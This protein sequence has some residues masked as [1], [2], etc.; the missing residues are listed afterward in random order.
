MKTLMSICT[1]IALAATGAAESAFDGTWTFTTPDGGAGWLSIDTA[2]TPPKVDMLWE[3][4]GVEPAKEA[5]LSRNTLAFSFPWDH[6]YMTASGMRR[7]NLGTLILRLIDKGSTVDASLSRIKNGATRLYADGPPIPLAIKRAAPMPPA[8]DVNAL[9][10]GDPIELFDGKTLGGWRLTNPKDVSGWSVKDGILTN[11]PKLE[12]G[13]NP[14]QFGNLRTDRVFEDFRL[15]LEV[16]LPKGGNS[17]IYL[18]GRYEVQVTDAFGRP[19]S[20]GIIGAIYSRVAPTANAAKPAGEWQT[21]D[22]TFADRHATVILNGQKVIDNQ[23][24]EGCTG[25]ALDADDTLPG[26]IYFQGDHTAVEYRN[27]KLYPRVK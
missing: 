12:D 17:G 8:P 24:V 9:K 6:W 4:G 3:T 16:R 18:R 5:N 23:P 1:G 11:E 21:F 27:I 22:I 19:P 25:G 7:D 20:K 15:T 2:A 10:F 14:P 13:D 26:P